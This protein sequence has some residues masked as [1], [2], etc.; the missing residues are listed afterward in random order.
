[1]AR[2][3]YDAVDDDNV[4][5]DNDS[6]NNDNNFDRLEGEGHNIIFIK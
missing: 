4:T 1:M 6:D 5:Y 2:V 3:Q